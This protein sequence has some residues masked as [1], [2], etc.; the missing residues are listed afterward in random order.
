MLLSGLHYSPS[1]VQSGGEPEGGGVN[2]RGNTPSIAHVQQQGVECVWWLRGKPRTETWIVTRASL[3]LPGCDF[4]WLWPSSYFPEQVVREAQPNSGDFNAFDS[5]P[6]S[7]SLFID[8]NYNEKHTHLHQGMKSCL[9][10]NVNDCCDLVTFS[11]TC[12]LCECLSVT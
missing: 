9:T 1:V 8:Q 2:L 5:T 7:F 4:G 6:F 10:I 3:T 12:S 11:R